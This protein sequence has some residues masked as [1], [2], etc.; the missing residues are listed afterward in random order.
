MDMTSV[1]VFLIGPFL[2]W[3]NH[4]AIFSDEIEKEKQP[5]EIIRIWSIVSIVSLFALMAVYVYFRLV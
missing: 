5:S 2:A 1:I 3:L 4:N